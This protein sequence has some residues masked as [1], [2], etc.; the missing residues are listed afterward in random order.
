MSGKKFAGEQK[1][2]RSLRPFSPFL[3]RVSALVAGCAVREFGTKIFASNQFITFRLV[4]CDDSLVFDAQ[5]FEIVIFHGR[6]VTI[7]K[8]AFV[9]RTDAVCTW[10]RW[11]LYMERSTILLST[12]QMRMTFITLRQAAISSSLS[13][14]GYEQITILREELV[15]P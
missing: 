5:T 4:F 9:L 13:G 3:Q 12:K 8:S 10:H 14:T 11:R 2:A 1:T 6:K 7:D 15:Q